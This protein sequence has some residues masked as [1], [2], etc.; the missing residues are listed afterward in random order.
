[1]RHMITARRRALAAMAGLLL[2]GTTAM[3]ASTVPQRYLYGWFDP[4]APTITVDEMEREQQS[5]RQR[6]ARRDDASTRRAAE[7]ERMSQ[8]CYDAA[9]AQPAPAAT[10][11]MPAPPPTDTVRVD[12][13][14]LPLE[15]LARRYQET[16]D[17][18]IEAAIRQRVAADAAARQ[19]PAGANPLP[20]L[21]Q[22]PGIDP[23]MA[24]PMRRAALAN[25]P[26][27][28]E[29]LRRAERHGDVVQPEV[30]RNFVDLDAELLRP[31]RDGR[32][33]TMVYDYA[34]EAGLRRIN[35][36]LTSSPHAAQ[37][38]PM[39]TAMQRSLRGAGSVEPSEAV[40]KRSQEIATPPPTAGPHNSKRGSLGGI[41]DALNKLKDQLKGAPR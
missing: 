24:E 4:A 11:S 36:V 26:R 41:G 19:A 35:V 5:H 3:A 32:T 27:V 18:A 25:D 1:M 7:S 10:P 21:G 33:D 13:R 6:E 15:E 28:Q 2:C 16:R 23:R 8:A 34:T 20:A 31:L 39:A 22:T 14:G 40:F 9:G 37:A 17:P 30:E 38:V 29:C 12:L